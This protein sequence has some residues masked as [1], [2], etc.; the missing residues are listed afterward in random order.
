LSALNL[1]A[2]PAKAFFGKLRD[3]ALQAKFGANSCCG[4]L[5]LVGRV[6]RFWQLNEDVS[7][8]LTVNGVLL[9]NS[10]PSSG[11]PGEEVEHDVIV[12][13]RAQL[14]ASSS[15]NLMTSG[16]RMHPQGSTP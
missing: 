16:N 2:S 8:R 6:E 14:D 4:L 12:P 3:V 13:T 11:R 5:R 10:L 15:E 7:T 1:Y 9:Q